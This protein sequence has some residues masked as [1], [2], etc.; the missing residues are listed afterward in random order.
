MK[1]KNF[2]ILLLAILLSA[3]AT[4]GSYLDAEEAERIQEQ[5]TTAQQLEEAL[6]PP[7]VTIPRDDG[8]VMW[9]YEG[10]HVRADPH[11]YVPYLG[12]LLGTNSK[13]CTR[14]T[15]LVDRENGQLSDWQYKTEEDRDYWAKTNDKCVKA[16]K[17]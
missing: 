4:K 7:S 5:V 10:I 11:S 15:V 8:T 17:D 2:P 13:E 3:C 14:L 9:V 1:K 16:D 12:L 6:G